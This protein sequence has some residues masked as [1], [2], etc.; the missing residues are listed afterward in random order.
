[1]ALLAGLVLSSCGNKQGTSTANSSPSE[2]TAQSSTPATSTT[3][4]KESTKTP[5][6]AS[7]K[8][9]GSTLSAEA[10]KL[11]VEPQGTECPSNAP[12]KGNINKKGNQMYH[13][14][15][16]AVYKK[17]KPVICFP[18]TATAQKAGFRAPKAAK[19]P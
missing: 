13:E 10:K 1:L 6:S 11:G 15:K 18:D 17:V 5:A 2:P 4:P 12:I 16:E 8:K 3:A 19:S 14:T 7:S 9:A